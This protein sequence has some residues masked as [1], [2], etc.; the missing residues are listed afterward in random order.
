MNKFIDDGSTSTTSFLSES[1]MNMSLSNHSNSG[2]FSSGGSRTTDSSV[3]RRTCPT[4]LAVEDFKDF[5]SKTLPEYVQDKD[6]VDMLQHGVKTSMPTTCPTVLAEIEHYLTSI[7]ESS[8]SIPASV[9]A[10]LHIYRGLTHLMR[11]DQNNAAIEAFTRALW[12]QTHLMRLAPDEQ[13][14]RLRLFDVALTEHRLGVAY[15]R[16]QQYLEAIDQMNYAIQSYERAKVGISEGCYSSA[17]EDLHE[18]TE[19][20]QLDLLRSSGRALRRSQIRRTKSAGSSDNLG[21]LRRCMSEGRGIRRPG[22][23]AI[24]EAAPIVPMEVQVEWQDS[25]AY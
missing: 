4:D 8:P 14:E 22:V 12:L 19:A 3:R 18:F 11:G 23:K 25:S 5:V 21:A 9:V 20:R 1:L 7:L 10:D 17:K 16:S 13:E 6:L 24:P 2:Y 15:G